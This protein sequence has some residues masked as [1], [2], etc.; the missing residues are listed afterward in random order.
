ML[1]RAAAV[2]DADR[3]TSD[4]HGFHSPV[5]A[6]TRAERRLAAF[7]L[8]REAAEDQPLVLQLGRVDVAAD[9]LD[10]HAVLREQRVVR[11]LIGGVRK[12]LGNRLRPAELLL[13]LLAHAIAVAVHALAE[14]PADRQVHRV[15]G[16]HAVDAP[17]VDPLLEQP[18]H[19]VGMRAGMPVDVA[20]P[21]PVRRRTASACASRC[22]GTADRPFSPRRGPRSSS[23]CRCRVRP[24][25]RTDRR[26]RRGRTAIRPGSRRWSCR[27]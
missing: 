21:R 15:I 11:Q 4:A 18:R 20:S 1:R 8:P 22:A 12:Q 26:S 24:S 3:S 16:G 17:D 23:A 27:W 14:E 2:S 6:T 19:H 10:V 25:R 7:E 5:N 9:V 13:G